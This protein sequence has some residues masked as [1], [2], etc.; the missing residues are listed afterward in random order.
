VTAHEQLLY[1][2][3][4]GAVELR[5]DIARRA[6]WAYEGSVWFR[7]AMILLT[8]L[9]G[10]TQLVG[11][12]TPAP[13]PRW[14]PHQGLAIMLGVWFVWLLAKVHVWNCRHRNEIS[15][16]NLAEYLEHLPRS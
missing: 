12:I 1:G 14:Q 5:Q 16:A 9:F 6:A 4:A 7:R 13:W 2:P 10:V 11:W 3:H 8:I 15:Q